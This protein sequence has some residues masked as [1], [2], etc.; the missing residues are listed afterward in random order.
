MEIVNGK[1]ST[2]RPSQPPASCRRRIVMFPMPFQGHITPMLHLANILHSQGFKIT[3]IHTEY[4]APNRSNYPHFTFRSISDRF[5]EIP[6]AELSAS[7]CIKYLNNYCL[8]PFRKFLAELLADEEEEEKVSCMITDAAFYSTQ[9]VA[10]ELGIPRL[11]L[12]TNS[13]SC[14]VASDILLSLSTLPKDPEALVMEFPP[15]KLK[16][17]GKGNTDPKGMGEVMVNTRNQMKAS[18][19]IIWNTFKELEE[20]ALETVCQDYRIPSFTLGP[21]HKYFT[22][23]SGGLIE[24][25]RNILSWLDTQAPKSVV[26]VSFGSVARITESDFQEMAHGLANT[27]LPFLWVVRPGVVRGSEWLESLP[28]KFLESVGDKGRIVKWCPQPKVLAHPATGCFWTHCGWNSTLESICEGVPMVC[29]PCFVD[30]PINSRCVC[31]V[32]KIGVILEDG[33]ERDGIETAIKSVMV[34]EEGKEMRKRINSIKDKMNLSL[35]KGV[36]GPHL[37]SLLQDSNGSADV[38]YCFHNT[39]VSDQDAAKS[40]LLDFLNMGICLSDLWSEF[41]AVDPR[42]A[43]LA[44]HLSGARVLRQ[45]PLECLI[46]FICSSN[47]N[48]KRITQMVDF[49]SSLGNHVGVVEGVDFYE[50]PSLDRLSKVSEEELRKAGFGYRAKYITGTVE[51]LQSKPGGGVE[52]LT[53]L[54]KLDLQNAIEA[55]ITL[56]G[57]GPKVAACIALFSLDQHHSVPVD[58]HVWKI[59]TR[60]LIPE[61]AGTRITPKLCS[62]VAD[63]F[64]EKYGR[65]AGWAQTLLFIAELPLQKAVLQSVTSES[66]EV[67]KDEPQKIPRMHG[68]KGFIVKW[69]PSTRIASLF[70]NRCFWTRK[71]RNSTSVTMCEGVPMVCSPRFVNK[72]INARCAC[73]TFGK[74]A[75]SCMTGLKGIGSKMTIKGVMVNEEAKKY[76]REYIATDGFG[77][78]VGSASGIQACATEGAGLAL[79]HGDWENLLKR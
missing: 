11:V 31:G 63:A 61:L 15:L 68:D 76:E 53:S 2:F 21:F 7:Y 10:D 24:Q 66:K 77:F 1:P 55:L 67:S 20:Y 51:V 34:N 13:L 27:G 50:F 35:E 5:S 33:F 40:A 42:F 36:V 25:D 78:M 6:A 72:P 71:Y 70:D 16:D 45:D 44:Q 39:P 41:S 56:P 74:L 54:R 38:A 30:Q 3:I 19:G 43:E 49:V 22:A 73:A 79:G 48:I 18:S 69:S 57:V 28:E 58:T 47:N 75:F 32:W 52:W 60:Y 26:Y 65:Y 12:E 8:D 46:Q 23:S 64:V 37:V 29:S 4:N 62:R 14:I 59:A 9:A 17:V